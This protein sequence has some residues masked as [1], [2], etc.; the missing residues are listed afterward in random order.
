[1]QVANTGSTESL[2]NYQVDMAGELREFALF[3]P[4]HTSPKKLPLVI[5]FHG[6]GATVWP[7]V[8]NDPWVDQARRGQAYLLVPQAL[9]SPGIYYTYW[10]TSQ[11]NNAHNDE[12][13][14]S[15]VLDQL[16]QQVD[17]DTD[18]IYIT[19]MSSGGFM[20]YY[21][22]LQQQSRIAAMASIAGLVNTDVIATY[23]MRKPMP[24]LHIHGTADTAINPLGNEFFAGWNDILGHLLRDNLVTKAATQ[25]KLPDINTSDHSTVTKFEYRGATPAS[26]I[27]YYQVNGGTHCVPGIQSDCNQDFNAYTTIWEFFTKHTLSN[28][29]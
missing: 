14:V 15:S 27:D 28:R 23:T 26:D 4:A 5:K 29:K 16:I 18:R 10:N 20:T 6:A 13:F 8:A 7:D 11:L 19:G 21:F 25:T 22:G 24:V 1:M 2:K 3:Q 12:R 9:K 17:I